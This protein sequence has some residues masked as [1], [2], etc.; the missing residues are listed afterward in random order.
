[1]GTPRRQDPYP[2]RVSGPLAAEVHG[3]RM[4]LV[5]A[6]YMERTSQDNA[7]VMACLS[8]WME[9]EGLAPFQLTADRVEQFA[10]A[11]REKGYRRWRTVWSLRLL[12]RHL[13]GRT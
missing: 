3:F 4:K 13:R 6:G 8:R 7:Y 9:A 5:H 1:M 2:A 12:L 10:Q 11:R